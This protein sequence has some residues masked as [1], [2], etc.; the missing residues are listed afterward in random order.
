MKILVNTRHMTLTKKLKNYVKRRLTFALGSR[1]D[2]VKRV[3][4]TLSDINGPKG[5][6]DKRC[7]MLLK[8]DGQGD[9]VIEDTQLHVYDAIDRAANKASQTVNKRVDR[10]RH[11]A[12]RIKKAI[13]NYRQDRRD[14][15]LEEDFEDYNYSWRES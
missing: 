12:K 6:E 11:K 14:R 4:V 15:Y 7:Q 1:F 13:Q 2:Q 10:I 3:E 8:L 9:I 5:G